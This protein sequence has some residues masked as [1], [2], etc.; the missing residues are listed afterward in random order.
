MP[1]RRASS[2][3]RSG[4]PGQL[5]ARRGAGGGDGRVDAAGVVGPPGHAGGELVAPVSG[6]DEMGVAVDEARQ[7]APPRG[8]DAPVGGGAGGAHGDDAIALHHH[9]RVRPDAEGPVAELGVVGDEQADVVDDHR[10][11]A[12]D[13]CTAASPDTVRSSSRA[14]SMPDMATVGD[15][16]LAADHDM[17][18]VGRGAR[19]HDGLQRMSG[20]GPGQAHRP[21]VDGHQVG[22]GTDGQGPDLRPADAGVAVDG[23]RP[24]AGRRPGGDPARRCAAARAARRRGPPRTG[25]SP[26]AS[27]CRAS[28]GLRRRA[29]AEP[30]RRRRPGRARSWG[31]STPSSGCG[32]GRRRR[33]R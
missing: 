25:R 20:V 32:R 8:V 18:H 5:A 24:R 3:R 15:D 27:R 22:R 13:A 23:G 7:D 11:D 16:D 9:G 29:A 30:G 26:R 12:H 17:V 4:Q 33:R 6:E 2:I 28:G 31:S 19:E 14:T 21:E 10:G 1:A